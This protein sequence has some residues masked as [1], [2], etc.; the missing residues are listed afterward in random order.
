MAFGTV[1]LGVQKAEAGLIC[2][3]LTVGSE[4][5]R[6]EACAEPPAIVADELNPLAVRTGGLTVFYG[7][8][9]PGTQ[10]VDLT[11]GAETRRVRTVQ[12]DGYEARFYATA[13]VDERTVLGAITLRDGDGDATAAADL[14]RAAL[15]LAGRPQ[16]LASIRGFDRERT[17]L[18]AIAPRV[19]ANPD[20][21][22]TRRRTALCAAIGSEAGSLVAQECA[23]GRRQVRVA[24]ARD[25]RNPRVIVF[26]AAPA[27]VRTAT[28]VYGAGRREPLDVVRARRRVGRR[29]TLLFGSAE[30]R[31]RLRRVLLFGR[32]G[33]RIGVARVSRTECER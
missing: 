10:R 31:A 3:D 27:S 32:G 8:V 20:R 17:G 15:K 6:D 28:A 30:G 7:M 21:S 9:R 29:G 18:F 24:Y 4:T 22:P 23:V 2:L 25:C 33:V 11:A 5:F 19:L 1:E 14:E 13:Y 26:G 16:R 12:P